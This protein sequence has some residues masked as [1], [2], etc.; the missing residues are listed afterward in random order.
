MICPYCVEDIPDYSKNH[1]KCQVNEG[2]EFPPHYLEHHGRAGNQ[3]PIV[4]SVIGFGGHG[5]TVFL[6]ALFHYIDHCLSKLW[7]GFHS[8]GL[9]Q[10]S[11]DTLY[12]ARKKLEDKILPERTI[13]I[14]PRPGIFRLNNMPCIQDCDPNTAL[15]NTTVLI[16][17]T[18]GE[19]FT[20]E[21][22]IVEFAH[23]VKR[24]DCVLFLVD[25]T[26][27]GNS[28]STE[29][30]R[31]LDTY[32]LA[33]PRMQIKKQAQHLI[34]VY[35]KSDDMKISVPQFARLLADEPGLEA[36][37]KE[38][39]PPSLGSPRAHLRQLDAVSRTL[40]DF[41]RSKLGAHKFIHQ[42]EEWFASVSYTA[43]T[44]LGTAPEM[45]VNEEGQ[46]E[47]RLAVEISPRCVA[48]PLLYVLDK[49]VKP[50]LS[51]PWW[52]QLMGKVGV[53][54]T[55][56]AAVMLSAAASTLLALVAGVYFLFFYNADY[57]RGYACEQQKDYAC[58]VENY[59]KAIE[60]SPEY[61]EAYNRR[62]WVNLEQGTYDEAFKDCSKASQLEADFAEAL[63]CRGMASVY[64]NS[65]DEALGDCAKAIELKPDYAEAYLCRGVTYWYRKQNAEAIKDYDK[66]IELVPN[67]ARAY[68]KRGSAHADSGNEAQSLSDY[69]QAAELEPELA[70]TYYYRDHV[71]AYNRRGSAYLKQ[72]NYKEAVEDFSKAIKL[73]PDYAEAFE[74]RA[75]AYM[76][77]SNYPESIDDFTEAIRLQP[78]N[79]TI[80]LSR[81]DAYTH[82]N[83]NQAIDD[84][85]RALQIKPNWVVAHFKR[86]GAY[87]GANKYDEA[88]KDYDKALELNPDYVE[89]YFERGQAYLKKGDYWRNYGDKK[90]AYDDY[91]M[92]VQDYGSAVKL[93]PEYAQAVYNKGIA[94][95]RRENYGEAIKDYKA[96]T[97]LDS[98]LES[99][100]S[101]DYSS[102]FVRHGKD[103]QTQGDKGSS[104]DYYYSLAIGDYTEAIRLNPKSFDAY[105]QRGWIY[106]EQKKYVE[107]GN[108]YTNAIAIN[109]RSAGA[110]NNRGV[111]YAGQGK[112]ELAKESYR[113][114][115]AL[116]PT[117]TNAQNNLASL[118]NR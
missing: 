97:S 20:S 24:S 109:G 4:L 107:A 47:L 5:K 100:P 59:T 14:F 112:S 91:Y 114:A 84:Y 83:Y 93:N 19:A 44:S 80:Y 21:A 28:I 25:L 45:Q 22:K 104:K 57:R 61:A 76:A 41:T 18:S 7:P 27:M 16:F 98:D 49:S 102:A 36:Y 90:K 55:A 64:N 8:N 111:A 73:K 31:L 66:A 117:N 1:P 48:D 26:T 63:T 15:E 30:G 29:M 118:E 6:C 94:N 58:A 65:Y 113:R 71:L 39:L 52:R 74:N 110:Y 11:L 53:V 96:A 67:F 75:T 69:R 46:E 105:F 68:I 12:V 37:L 79:A 101:V 89:A 115:L 99:L 95:A 17:D 10:E 40:E 60:A 92:A 108:D 116:D 86:G 54:G 50:K 77:I 82:I 9:D 72:K 85:S 103:Y 62:G 70:T 34:V 32:V 51:P 78:Q 38:Q 56:A 33:M 3:E 2:K 106:L 35:T 88:I 13:Q 43:V 42:A 87:A 23:Y 81:G